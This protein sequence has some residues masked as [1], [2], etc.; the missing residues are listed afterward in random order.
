MLHYFQSRL[1]IGHI[2]AFHIAV[3]AS[4]LVEVAGFVVMLLAA[5]TALGIDRVEYSLGSGVTLR[6]AASGLG[7]TF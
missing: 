7:L 3:G 5:T 6:A 2:D 1:T 4:S